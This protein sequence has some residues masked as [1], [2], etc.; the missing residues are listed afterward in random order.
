LSG[1]LGPGDL[2]ALQRAALDRANATVTTEGRL[3]TK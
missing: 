2:E 3:V 1:A